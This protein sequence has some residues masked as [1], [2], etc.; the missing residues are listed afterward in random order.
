M[1]CEPLEGYCRSYDSDDKHLLVPIVK[2]SASQPEVNVSGTET[3]CA[4]PLYQSSAKQ[5]V[6][7]DQRLRS[8][9]LWISAVKNLLSIICKKLLSAAGRTHWVWICSAE[10]NLLVALGKTCRQFH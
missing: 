3:V 7:S 1:P 2:Q 9:S 6:S 10:T 5:A 4:E 8:V